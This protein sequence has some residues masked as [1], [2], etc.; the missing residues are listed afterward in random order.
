MKPTFRFQYQMRKLVLSFQEPYSTAVQRMDSLMLRLEL[1][2][3]PK[4]AIIVLG[5]LQSTQNNSK[6]AAIL[7]YSDAGIGMLTLN[8]AI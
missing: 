3:Q 5:L 4:N 6:E 1:L 7:N 2:D 8:Q